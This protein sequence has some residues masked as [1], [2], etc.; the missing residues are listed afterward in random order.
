[1][2]NCTIEGHFNDFFFIWCERRHNLCYFYHNILFDWFFF[3]ANYITCY[4]SIIYICTRDYG[5]RNFLIKGVFL[6]ERYRKFGV[7]VNQFICYQC[8]YCLFLGSDSHFVNVK[9]N[10][11]CEEYTANFCHCGYT[12][13]FNILKKNLISITLD[14]NWLWGAIHVCS[15]L[16]WIVWMHIT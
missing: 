4:I 3:Y 13:D 10:V 7:R 14:W 12:I 6:W 15:Y 16:F 11:V 9:R 1:M 2:H 8:F 5:N